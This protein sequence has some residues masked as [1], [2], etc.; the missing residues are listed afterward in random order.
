L[1]ARAEHGILGAMLTRHG[2][3]F[4]LRL[5]DTAADHAAYALELSTADGDW[6]TS[7]TVSS[8][9]GALAIAAWEG[10]SAPPAWLE[11]YVRAALREAWRGH[12]ERGWPRRLQRWRAPPVARA[13]SARGDDES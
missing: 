1:S 12:A 9:D 3:R 7:V 8:A 4:G 6:S 13:E 2:G 10:P 5:V 11:Q